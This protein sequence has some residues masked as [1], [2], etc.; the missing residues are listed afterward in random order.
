[1]PGSLHFEAPTALQ[2]FAA[3]VADDAS[4]SPLEAAISVAQDE[5][6]RLD[7]QATLAQVDEL[8]DRLHRRIAVDAAPLQR[9]RQLNR[10]FFHE[11]GFAGN[12]NDY[13]DARNS[14]L[15]DVLRT[16]RGIP[17][18]LALLYIE[19]AAQIGLQAAGI[20][21][22]GHF[23]VKLHMPRGEVVIDPFTGQS[24]SREDLD[25]RL[26]PY[27]RQRGLTGDFEA[28]LGLFLQAAPPRDVIARLLRNLKEIH[29]TAEDWPRLLPVLE[30]LVV[31]LPEAWDERRDR[32]LVRAELGRFAEAAEDLGGYL[33]HHP[34][35]DDA[36]ALRRRLAAWRSGDGPRWH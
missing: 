10:Y 20:S 1:M 34:G 36:P 33:D 24:L 27:R 35:A 21:F 8:A 4:L 29:R 22:P 31:L 6:P 2:Y 15:P 26:L 12:V 5:Y 17:I 32:G 18:T 7:V 19:L 9:L 28:P 14:Y 30:R 16:R 23:L 25:E 13:Y 11:L 3:L